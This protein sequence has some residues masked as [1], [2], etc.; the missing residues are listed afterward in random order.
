MTLLDTWPALTRL[1]GRIGRCLESL[2]LHIGAPGGSWMGEVFKNLSLN[3]E[4]DVCFTI[5]FL[6]VLIMKKTYSPISLS[7]NIIHK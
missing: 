6:D 5:A 4:Q 3:L 7:G 2:R 1:Q